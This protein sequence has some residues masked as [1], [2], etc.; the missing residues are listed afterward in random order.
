[1]AQTKPHCLPSQVA[2]PF[3]GGVHSE[4]ELPQV[5]TESFGSQLAPHR[6]EPLSQAKPH[7]CP[8]QVACARAGAEQTLQESPQLS[9]VLV[10]SG[11][12]H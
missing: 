11:Q 10:P 3:A 9:T 5:A 6:C 8:S 4:Q 12:V 2:V 7:W 1:M